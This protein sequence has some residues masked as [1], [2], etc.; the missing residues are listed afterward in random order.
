MEEAVFA[1]NK[2]PHVWLFFRN[3]TAVRF[4]ARAVIYYKLEPF[5]LLS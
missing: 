4:L 1:Y 3:Q 5:Y 2:Q